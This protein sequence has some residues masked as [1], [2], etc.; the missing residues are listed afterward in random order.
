[1]IGLSH[2]EKIVT[3]QKENPLKQDDLLIY[4]LMK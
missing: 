1:M 3:L 2:L 4:L